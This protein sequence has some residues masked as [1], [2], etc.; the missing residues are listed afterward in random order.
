MIRDFM[1]ALEGEMEDLSKEQVTFLEIGDVICVYT[2]SFF[3]QF[4]SVRKC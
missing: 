1:D 3:A 2:R 4:V